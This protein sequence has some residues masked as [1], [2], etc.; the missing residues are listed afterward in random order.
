[1]D[2][3]D[4]QLKPCKCGYEV[5]PLPPSHRAAPVLCTNQRPVL[6]SL[7]CLRVY[8]PLQICVWCWH[9][10]IDMAEKED[11]EGRCPACRTRYDK[12]RIVKMAA[13]TCDR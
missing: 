8:A 11:T 12:D 7:F 5:P 2:I 10:I 13:A 6:F 1:M 4:Q 3:T 9:H